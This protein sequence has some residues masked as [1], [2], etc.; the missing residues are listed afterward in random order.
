[1]AS[2]LLDVFLTTNPD[3]E[4]IHWNYVDLAGL[5]GSR[6]VPKSI[7]RELAQQG[8]PSTLGSLSTIGLCSLNDLPSNFRTHGWD[9]LYPD[10][11]SLR[12]LDTGH[13]SVM[14]NVSEEASGHSDLVME[15]PF[16]RCSRSAL[17]RA[18]HFARNRLGAMIIAGFEVE[19]YLIDA[20]T[21]KDPSL[22]RRPTY[23][24][25][26][27][28]CSLRGIYAECAFECVKALQQ[29]G[30]VANVLHA[31]RGPQQFQIPLGAL[32]VLKSVDTLMQAREIIR[33]AA[34]RRNMRAIFLPEPFK[35]LES[36]GL[37]AHLSFNQELGGHKA[38]NPY[39]GIEDSFMA[40]LLDH[41]PAIT[42]FGMP[43]EY[44]YAR[45]R[46]AAVGKWVAW[47]TGNRDTPVRRISQNRWEL[48]AI[49]ATSNTYLTM[50]AYIAFGSLGA[51]ARQKLRL[52]DTREFV[53]SLDTVTLRERRIDTQMP[54]S[55]REAL[56]Q[57]HREKGNENLSSVLGPQILDFYLAVKEGEI[58]TLAS[59]TERDREDMYFEIY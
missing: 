15:S 59:M 35:E 45:V 33:R 37:H 46:A 58:A 56:T 24:F 14:C 13:A 55:F 36:C 51:I 17:Q 1:M 9:S 7:C 11:T 26:N 3:V 21:A 25:L 54:G 29:T 4:F 28:A 50:A 53:D 42:A 27:G 12:K 34:I 20:A 43:C 16:L 40:G 52:Q 44:S 47:G 39:E 5:V 2:M 32:P 31:I 49:D 41:L 19:F 48:R 23:T 6:C 57:L 22:F 38:W 30:I 10:W 8:T 18:V